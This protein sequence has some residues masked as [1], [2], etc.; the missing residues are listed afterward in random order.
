MSNAGQEGRPNFMAAP[1]PVRPLLDEYADLNIQNMGAGL[2]ARCTPN[3]ARGTADADAY[4][5]S[6]GER[7]PAAG[8]GAALRLWLNVGATLAR[9]MRQP[10]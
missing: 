9:Y 2:H 7:P 6:T 1:V 10:E 8:G 3:A 5:T 4:P